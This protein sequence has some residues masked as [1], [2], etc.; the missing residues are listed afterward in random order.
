MRPN[1]G[2]AIP[3]FLHQALSNLPITVFGDGGQTRSFCFVTDLIE[4][5]VRLIR[6]DYHQPVNIGNPTEFTILELAEAV[7]RATGSRSEV[8]YEALP[9]DDPTIRQPDITLARA[10]LGWEPT[11]QLEQGLALTIDSVTASV[12]GSA[13]GSGS[14]IA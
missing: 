7:I 4:G 14:T 8:V 2:R 5:L 9:Q 1:D 12:A 6:S 11:I 13:G 10:L 3:T